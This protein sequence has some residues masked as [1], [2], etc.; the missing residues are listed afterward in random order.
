[1]AYSLPTRTRD[2]PTHEKLSWHLQELAQFERAYAKLMNT[3]IGMTQFNE[4]AGEE[5]ASS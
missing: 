1:M 3:G 4:E 2:A 5:A